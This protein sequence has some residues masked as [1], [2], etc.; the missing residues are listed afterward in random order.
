MVSESAQDY[1]KAIW[2]LQAARGEATTT[3]LA[4][5]AGRLAGL[6]DRDA[7]EARQARAGATTSRTTAPR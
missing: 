2:K 3:A 1:L 6:G 4:G 5:G 7:E